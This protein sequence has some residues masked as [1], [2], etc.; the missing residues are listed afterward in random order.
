MTN[1]EMMES[2]IEVC[3]RLKTGAFNDE[4]PRFI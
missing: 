3:V 4:T 2:G 1:E